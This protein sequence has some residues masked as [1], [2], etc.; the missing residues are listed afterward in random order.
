MRT[1]K[2]LAPH[3]GR[4]VN[5][6]VAP[7]KRPAFEERARTLP[8]LILNA[9]G[10]SDLLLLGIG[11]FSPLGAAPGD[12]TALACVRDSIVRCSGY[13]R[14]RFVALLKYGS[15]LLLQFPPASLVSD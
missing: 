11:A 6:L 9:R 15:S 7:E 14:L 2:A 4:L 13:P 10:V 3:G 8:R 12:E 5:L 1:Q